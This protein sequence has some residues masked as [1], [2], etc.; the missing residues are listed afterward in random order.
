M[1]RAAQLP[2]SVMQTVIGE[3]SGPL[4]R[5]QNL[6][7]ETALG[8]VVADALQAGAA[9]FDV[10]KA[11]LVD[12]AD[13]RSGLGDPRGGPAQLTVGDALRALPMR[14]GSAV[15]TISGAGLH[16]AL[17]A[18]FTAPRGI[19]QVSV[20][21]AY[22]WNEAAA[23]GQRVDPG[24]ITIDGTPVDPAA[25]YVIVVSEGLRG[26]AGN[27]VIAAAPLI[28]HGIV[29]VGGAYPGPL[30]DNLAAYL[31]TRSPLPVPALNRI[32]RVG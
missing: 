12:L 29:G 18:Q 23:A 14:T 1:A 8:D 25:S 26:P 31:S 24:T 2:R 19:M 20:Q 10:N 6:A 32:T 11:A 15:I 22:Q 7:G 17:E 9:P 16:Q 13:L 28:T 27:P 4:T 5:D 3:L 21:F 30:F